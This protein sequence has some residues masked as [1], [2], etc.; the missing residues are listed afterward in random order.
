MLMT[1]NPCADAER[2]ENE[3]DLRAAQ[4]ETLE[5]EA[6]RMVLKELQDMTTTKWCHGQVSGP[7]HFTPEEIFFDAVD[8]DDDTASA[9]A[10]L[11]A[12]PAATEV[13][14]CAGLFHAKRYWRDIA[15]IPEID[16]DDV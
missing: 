1:A 3:Q 11:M 4:A 8:S 14:K 2:W 7:R 12:N 9:L 13:L 16:R 10:V 5:I 6:G 15:G